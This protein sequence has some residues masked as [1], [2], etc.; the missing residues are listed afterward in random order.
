MLHCLQSRAPCF[1]D[2]SGR[3]PLSQFKVIL[4]GWTTAIE[5]TPEL[6]NRLHSREHVVLQ[7]CKASA[8]NLAGNIGALTIR[9]GF[10]GPLYHNYNQDTSNIVLVKIRSSATTAAD[11]RV[12]ARIHFNVA[13]ATRL[14]GLLDLGFRPNLN[15]SLQDS[16]FE[17]KS[18]CCM[19][20]PSCA[21][22]QPERGHCCKE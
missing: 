2:F 8:R 18:P 16:V 1:E 10:W 17:S 21:S 6:R 7:L 22:K 20:H 5:V 9:I 14:P 15:A 12:W 4:D 3:S 13:P 19:E 11:R